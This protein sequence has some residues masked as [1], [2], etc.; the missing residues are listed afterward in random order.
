MGIDTRTHRS[1]RT[2]AVDRFIS[3]IKEIF[4][5]DE[6]SFEEEIWSSDDVETPVIGFN[7]IK[8]TAKF[9]K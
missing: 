6:V 4:E 8:V 5:V 3:D 7:V 9:R 2:K 1:E